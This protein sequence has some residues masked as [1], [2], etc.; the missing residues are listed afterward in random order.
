VR[1]CWSCSNS[2]S[3]SDLGAEERHFDIQVQVPSK[4]AYVV[5]E[6]AT[7]RLQVPRKSHHSASVRCHKP[8]TLPRSRVIISKNLRHLCLDRAYFVGALPNAEDAVDVTTIREV[9]EAFT[10]IMQQSKKISYF[11]LLLD[12]SSKP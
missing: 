8:S 6:G 10:F 5:T 9:V 11:I 7:Q 12:G 2:T 4:Q 1:K 3:L